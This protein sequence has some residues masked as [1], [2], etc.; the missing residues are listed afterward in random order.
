MIG[1]RGCYRYI[2]DPETFALELDAL[3]RNPGSIPEPARDDPVRSNDV[4][5]RSLPRGDRRQPARSR[6]ERCGC[7]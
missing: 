1:F 2:K 6:P 5:A 3:A 7:G 4:G